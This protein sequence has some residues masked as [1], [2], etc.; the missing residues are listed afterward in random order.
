MVRSETFQAALCSERRSSVRI[1][2]SLYQ[3]GLNPSS[4]GVT[5]TLIRCGLFVLFICFL[6]HHFKRH[7]EI[8]YTACKCTTKNIRLSHKTQ[9]CRC[10]ILIILFNLKGLFSDF[11]SDA[12]LWSSKK[13]VFMIL[14]IF[15]LIIKN[16]VMI[17]PRGK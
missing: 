8:Q 1:Y 7:H 12:S 13:K 16:M 6:Y 5:P 9:F 4:L 15:S 14:G 3:G 17:L 11:S 10:I 2:R